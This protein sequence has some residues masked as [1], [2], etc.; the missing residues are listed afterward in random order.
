M[1]SNEFLHK[2]LSEVV[3]GTYAA[4]DVGKAP[5]LPWFVYLPR[6]G[7]YFHAD[8][9]NYSRLPRYGVELYF[10]ENDPKLIEDF[11]S[12]LSRI[13]TWVRYSA[14]YVDAEHCLMHSYRVSVNLSKLRES[15]SQDG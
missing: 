4:Y 3:P 13:G 12:A 7:D 11:E 1:T 2:T 15:E 5:P 8:N 6:N 14:E 10:K 9:E